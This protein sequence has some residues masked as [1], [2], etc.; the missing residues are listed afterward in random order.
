M[1]Q[2][3]ECLIAGGPHH[4]VLRRQLWDP[5]YQA[6]PALASGDGNVCTAAACRHIGACGNRFLLVH[7][8]A[9][10]AQILAMMSRL[11]TLVSTA[12]FALPDFGA[13]CSNVA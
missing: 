10:G 4:G 8:R 7:P 13:R 5:H 9:T 6:P 3:V 11:S 12:A 2:I 1:E